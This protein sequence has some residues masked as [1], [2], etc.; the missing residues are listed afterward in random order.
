M[1]NKGIEYERKLVR[2]LYMEGFV[3]VRTAGSGGGSTQ[4]KPDIIVGKDNKQYA[5]EL[6]TSG[7]DDIYI[8]DEQIEGLVVFAR[9]FGA[10]PLVCVKFNRLPFVFMRIESLE[11]TGRQSYRVT[12]NEAINLKNRGV[13]KLEHYT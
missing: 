9:L 13:Y 4:P 5:I 8:R 7:Q 3:G 10:T 12:R 11:H 1:A 2:E 6:K